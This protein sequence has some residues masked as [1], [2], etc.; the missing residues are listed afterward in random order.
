MTADK[1]TLRIANAINT[2]FDFGRRVM[3]GMMEYLRHHPQFD[4]LWFQ[5]DLPEVE[6][7]RDWGVNGM[8]GLFN[9]Q[10]QA[11][12]YAALNIPLINASAVNHPA[13]MINVQ[14]NQQKIG[15]QAAAELRQLRAP[16][17]AFLGLEGRIFSD[18]REEGFQE[19]LGERPYEKFILPSKMWLWLDLLG[20]WLHRLPK[21]CGIFCAGDNEA[22]ILLSCCRAHGIQVPSEIAVI[23]ANNDTDLCLAT[24][25]SLSSIPNRS[26]EIG[27]T[28]I[29]ELTRILQGGTIDAHN[30]LIEPGETV[31]R[32]ST[33]IL[34]AVE[35]AKLEKALQFIR[36]NIHRN[37]GVDEVAR[38]FGASRR[39]TE[40][41]FRKSLQR[42]PL[43]EIHR[44]R[45]ANIQKKLLETDDSLE[46]IALQSGLKSHNQLHAFFRKNT[47]MTPDTY[48][49][50]YRE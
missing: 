2:T 26:R 22:R 39:A 41:H 32:E 16:H 36:D 44:V 49:R 3:L 28:A 50:K 34:F 30:Y 19:G 5:E 25:P 38:S 18:L 9:N 45:L 35:N 29:K 47:K 27:K 14:V 6:L 1:K 46:T 8:V 43:Q 12:R 20:K 13:P 15:Q 17:F 11:Q 42:T 37:I 10:E 24:V 31:H 40:L 48:R 7:L 21:P 33:N 23:S 4:V